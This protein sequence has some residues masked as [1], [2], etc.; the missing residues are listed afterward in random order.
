[1]AAGVLYLQL[2]AEAEADVAGAV[3][4]DRHMLGCLLLCVVIHLDGAQGAGTG[5]GR[6]GRRG[7]RL[8][9]G[10]RAGQGGGGQD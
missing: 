6:G 3:R 10:V 7:L 8:G 9:R 5:G 1:M 2:P 4:R